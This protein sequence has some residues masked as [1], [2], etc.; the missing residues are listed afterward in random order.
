MLDEIDTLAIADVALMLGMRLIDGSILLFPALAV[1]ILAPEYYR[2]IRSFASDFHASLDGRNAL[3]RAQA[4]IQSEAPAAVAAE[5]APWTNESVLQVNHVGVNYDAIHALSDIC[6]T[7]QGT[8]TYG[9][10]GPS[11]AGKST[12]AAVLAGF[13][14]PAEGAFVGG[15]VDTDAAGNN[16]ADAVVGA[17]DADAA[18]NNSTS[19]S[20]LLP[21][22]C[23]QAW[24]K[25]VAYIPQNPYIFHDTLRENLRF[26]APHATDEAVLAAIHVLGL[27][28][29]LEE[30]DDGLDTLIGD[31]A[32]AL[33]GGQAQRVALARAMLDDSRRI[34]V[35]DEPTAHLDIETEM[36]LKACMLR[37]M[38]GRLVFFA[39]HR[40]HWM[41]NMDHIFVLEDGRITD[42]GSLEE[43][44]QNSAA[45]ARL[46]A[47]SRMDA[48]CVQTEGGCD[49]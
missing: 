5:L 46:I 32:R 29:L 26:Y 14:E 39:T 45:F 15:T 44:R 48:P 25:Q 24:Q 9:I 1:L 27:D 16:S 21:S 3:A 12:F 30:L 22:L 8:C 20:T 33:S 43:L 7:A 19:S 42:E 40:L 28:S 10:I 11:G 35:F 38:E 17:A 49:E 31:G 18:K 41:R 34:L 36:E 37:L 47:N 6:F 23:E 2:P 13:L 4:V